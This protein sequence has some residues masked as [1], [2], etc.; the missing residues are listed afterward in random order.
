MTSQEERD[1]EENATPA[2]QSQ[3]FNE[4]G[5]VFDY[6]QSQLSA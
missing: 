5:S 4:R 6:Q 2:K 3:V 1:G